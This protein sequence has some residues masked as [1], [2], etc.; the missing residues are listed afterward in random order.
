MA[1]NMVLIS[2]A[3]E[4]Y[5]SACLADDGLVLAFSFVIE[6]ACFSG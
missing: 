2:C 5:F 6:A 4:H 1:F 3:A